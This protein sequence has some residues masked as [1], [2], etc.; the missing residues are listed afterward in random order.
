MPFNQTQ[1]T[2]FNTTPV[3]P[4]HTTPQTL[5]HLLMPPPQ[6]SVYHHDLQ[7]PQQQQPVLGLI[8]TNPY[9]TYHVQPQTP[10][11]YQT[12]SPLPFGL[13]IMPQSFY[14][15]DMS[16]RDPIMTDQPLSPILQLQPPP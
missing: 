5:Q 10:N 8:P 6:S 9:Q 14:N 12:L 13:D 16:I 15:E 7:P 4:G 1:S 3:N 11:I 2:Q